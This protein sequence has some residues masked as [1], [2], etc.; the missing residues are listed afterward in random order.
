MERLSARIQERFPDRGLSHVAEEILSVAREASQRSRTIGRP[1]LPLRIVG[2]SL[3]L[4]ILTLLGWILP[5]LN[6]AALVQGEMSASQFVGLL[7]PTLGSAVFLGAGMLFLFS[8]EGRFR[9]ARAQK[10]LHELRSLA[11]VI[12]M[13]QLT[14]DPERLRGTGPD[15]A[16]SP[17]RD[18]TPFLLSRYFDYCVEM[19]AVLSKIA[20]LY[21]Q[22][23]DDAVALETVDQLES[24]TTGLSRKIWQKM[25]ILDLDDGDPASALESA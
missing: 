11:H 16:S 7:E 6:Y 24:L 4:A 14:K 15:T 20:A 5:R 21:V 9:R 12:D 22:E 25:M 17:K 3:G 23:Y 1:H 19:L 8:L 18:M 13:H 10:S 2:W